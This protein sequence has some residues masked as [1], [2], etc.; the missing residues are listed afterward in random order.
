VSN[1]CSGALLCDG[2]GACVQ[3]APPV[4]DTSNPCEIGTCDP[5]T[6]VSYTPAPEGTAC[7]T[8]VNA[9]AGTYACNA[10]GT[11]VQGPAPV[12]DTSNPCEIGTCDPATGITYAPAPAGTACGPNTNLCD[13]TFTCSGAGACNANPPPAISPPNNCFTGACDPATG[14]VTYAPIAGCDPN[15]TTGGAFET[16]ASILGQVAV[17]GGGTL[18]GYTL[19]AY[20]DSTTNAPRSD[21]SATVASDGSFRAR[22]TSFP[23]SEPDRSPPHHIIVRID[24]PGYISAYRGAYVHPGMAVN[25]GTINMVPFDPAVTVIGA[26]G[27]TATDSQGLVEIDVPAGALSVDTPIQITPFKHRADLPY[28]LPDVTL[29]GYAMDIEPQGSRSLIASHAEVAEKRLVR[30]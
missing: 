30:A 2:A 14:A 22:F 29:P 10:T 26:A 20:D 7:G 27:G 16:Q 28:P 24:L 19:T 18:T 23:T 11:C 25:A 12:I 5:T 3:G 21:L 1:A 15:P 8:T 4:I 9:C 17:S 6:G 13:T